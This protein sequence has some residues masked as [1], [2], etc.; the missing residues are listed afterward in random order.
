MHT[1]IPTRSRRSPDGLQ[2]A[3]LVGA[4]GLLAAMVYVQTQKRQVEREH[5]PQG[6]FI[7]VDGVRLHYVER[8]EGPALVLLHGNGVFAADFEVSG[9]LERA[10]GSYRVIAFDRPG[11]GYSERPDN[12]HWTP[13]AQAKLL[14]QALHQLGIERPLL[15]GHSWGTMVALAMAIEFPKYIRAITL[16]SGYYYPTARPDV[17]LMSAPALPGLGNVLR[18]TIAPVLG[19]MLWG[20]IVKRMFAPEPVPARFQQVP[21]W[22]AL[23]PSQ[24][25]ASA[26]E[27]AMMV[28]AAKRLSARYAELTM[29]VAILAGDAD[30]I[31]DPGH[32][33]RRLHED[34][35]HSEL[36]LEPGVGHMA[37]YAAPERIMQAVAS[38]EASL[39]PG[40]TNL[41][42][43]ATLHQPPTSLH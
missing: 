14:Y 1:V 3:A 15:V 24:I 5:P 43:S 29:P 11:F 26:S 12:N 13:E 23:R 33:A 17:P 18:N 40:G 2:T 34:I 31:V 41:R 28:P 9:L 7:D 27:T 32:H 16:V 37:H 4:A 21:K 36:I 25:G 10:A 39:T 42:N 22:M 20:G 6:K 8:G 19:R 38:L 30:G 35:A